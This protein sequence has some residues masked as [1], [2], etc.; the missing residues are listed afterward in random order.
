MFVS[1]E[2]YANATALVI[3]FVVNNFENATFQQ[4]AMAWE[5]KFIEFVKNYSNP[6]ITVNFMG[7]VSETGCVGHREVGSTRYISSCR[8]G[9]NP[10]YLLM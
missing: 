1:G 7:E 10:L 5:K 4:Q 8:T 9:V 2:N 6:N 3:T